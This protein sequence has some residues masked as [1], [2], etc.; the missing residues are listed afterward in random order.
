MIPVDIFFKISRYYSFRFNDDFDRNPN[1]TNRRSIQILTSEE[2]DD[3]FGI[4]STVDSF[5]KECFLKGKN[6]KGE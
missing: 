6:K 4:S 2:A 3:M 1:K 5:L